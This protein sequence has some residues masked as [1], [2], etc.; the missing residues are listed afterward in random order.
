MAVDCHLRFAIAMAAMLLLLFAVLAAA[1][2][3]PS[4]VVSFLLAA[5]VAIRSPSI[6]FS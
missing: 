5:D 3:A 2:A 1:L 6:L 4:V